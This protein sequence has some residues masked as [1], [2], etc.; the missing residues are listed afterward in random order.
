MPLGKKDQQKSKS[1]DERGCVCVCA[2][3][4]VFSLCV[5]IFKVRAMPS[6]LD[7]IPFVA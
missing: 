7:A 2:R 1:K 3:V 4:C 6:S 5:Y